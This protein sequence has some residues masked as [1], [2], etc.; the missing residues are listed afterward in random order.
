MPVGTS[1]Q[2]E[3]D[4]GARHLISTARAILS[5]H[6]ISPRT[7]RYTLPAIGLEGEN[8]GFVRSLLRWVDTLAAETGVRWFCL[9]FDFVGATVRGHRLETALDIVSRYPRLFLNLIVSDERSLS[10]PAIND[11]ARLVSRI[12]RKSNN[13]FDNFRVGASCG[14]PANAPFFPFS[15]HEGERIAFSF[16]LETT[17]L[18]LSVAAELGRAPPIDRYR[19]RFVERLVAMLTQVHA[20]GLEIERNTD[21]DYRGLDASLAPFPDGRTSVAALIE[22]LLGA[23]FGAQ[24]SVFITGVLT[25]ALRAAIDKSGARAVGFNGVMF[26]LLEDNALAA[27]NSRR[28]MNFDTLVATS[29]VCGCGIDMVPVSGTS[30]PEEIAAVILDIAALATSLSKPLGVRLLPIPNRSAN[31]FTAFNMDFLC[32]SRIVGLAG[33]DRS[34]TADDHSFA[35]LSP[36]L[37]RR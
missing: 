35:L 28:L 18:A 4:N 26:S 22:R 8:E 16:A 25:D 7:F 20:V 12:A 23:E 29:A 2:S 21:C 6:R 31:E 11:V 33:H 19:S 13:G 1:S 24:G 5:A 9:P 3:I 37:L 32:D 17:E 10:V 36:R 30:F 15:R 14:C 34:L 27:A